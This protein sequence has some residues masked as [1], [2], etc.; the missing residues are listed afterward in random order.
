MK[1]LLGTILAF[2]V[3]IVANAQYTLQGSV[4]E[5]QSKVPVEA[6][7]VTL[8]KNG[9]AIANTT[10]DD[11]G[12]YMFKG[13]HKPG[14][15][16]LVVES[17][18]MKKKIID[19]ELYSK[20]TAADVELSSYAY[21]LEPLELRS[22]RAG[23][24]AP[25]AKTNIGKEEIAAN[26]LGQDL[27]FIL[28]QTP[29]VVVNSDAGNGIGYTGIRIRGSDATRVNVT[30]NGIPYNDAESQGSY[31]VDLPDIA[32]S[33]SSIQVQ[34]GIGTSSNGTGAFGASLNLSTNEFNDKAYGELNNSLGSFNSWKNT[35][36]VG[37]GLID[38]HWTVDARLSRVSSDGY[39]DRAATDLKS[40]YF[41]TAYVTKKSTLRFNFISGKEKTYQ[42]WN[43][44]PESLLQLHRTY[45]SAGTEKSGEPYN[46]ETDNYIQDHYQLFFNHAFNNYLSVNTGLFLSKGRGYYEQYRAAA[47]YTDYGLTNPVIGGDTLA[48]IDLVRQLW[49]DNNYYGQIFSVQYKKKADQLTLGGG[50]TRYE[51]NHF[52]KI[53]WAQYNIAKDYEY[54]RLDA[55]K[56]DYKGYIKWLRAVT[57]NLD[58]YADMQYRHVGYNING[59]RNNPIIKVNRT[60]DFINPKAGITYSHKGYQAF[61]SYAKGNKEPNRDDFEANVLQQPKHEM[62]H[63][64][65]LGLEKKYSRLSW[66]ATAYYMLYKN[67]LIL[68]GQIND[69]GA[70]TRANVPNSYRV[71][72]ELQSKANITN[73]L[74]VTANF[75]FSQN[76]IK[77]AYEYQDDYDNGVQVKI[78]HE[79]ANISFSPSVVGGATI[80]FIPLK[81]MQ[82]SLLEKYVSRQYLD[83]TQDKSRSLKPY[84]VQ[85]ARLSYNVPGKIINQLT[86]MTAAYNIFNKKYEP[87]GYTFSYIYGGTTTTENYYFP[88]AG[89]H[90]MVGV[91]LKF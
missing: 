5:Q 49:L 3:A 34:R 89:R 35:V 31:F 22:V 19:I 72:I 36:K 39:I 50:W 56:K 83:N 44:V 10:T 63:D 25:F 75:A 43:G 69:V 21:F 46:N 1:H 53:I 78:L 45:N 71:G 26:N 15:Y 23:E 87:N 17:I 62:L 52:G 40:L 64:F 16:R 81:N 12:F 80:N 61:V 7:T 51:G 11:A 67:Q 2:C 91:N 30:I 58:I 42:A 86:I 82:L 24:R 41:S 38:S 32:S 18:S 14:S 28:N 54:Y 88:M 77:S 6:A 8:E 90:F 33:L 29:S 85:D 73:W 59:F 57:K 47:A 68:T 20:V 70:Y 4:H 60:F 9:A 13:I 79:N 48:A 65:E 84:F 55:L 74:I 27:P 76:K 37:S 66:S